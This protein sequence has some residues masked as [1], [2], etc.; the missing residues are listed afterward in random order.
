MEER[1]YAIFACPVG[2]FGEQIESFWF[3]SKEICGWNEAHNRIPHITLV[4]FFKVND[5]CCR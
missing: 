5:E 2:S 3:D 1:E 4:S